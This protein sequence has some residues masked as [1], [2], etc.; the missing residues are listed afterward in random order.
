[1]VDDDAL[2]IGENIA[3]HQDIGAAHAAC[4]DVAS[5]DDFFH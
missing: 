3:R 2:C 5:P 4:W 1:L